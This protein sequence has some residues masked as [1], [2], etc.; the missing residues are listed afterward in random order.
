[1]IGAPLPTK[2]PAV[3]AQLIGAVWRKAS[4]SAT[5]GQCVEIAHGTG[6]VGIRDSKNRAGGRL[7]LPATAWAD[8]LANAR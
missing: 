7:I 5:S 6:V 4:R 2:G 3:Q 1:M 8:F